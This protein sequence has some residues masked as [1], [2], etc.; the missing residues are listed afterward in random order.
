MGPGGPWELLKSFGV[1]K[2]K[3]LPGR[4]GTW[5]VGRYFSTGATWQKYLYSLVLIYAFNAKDIHIHMPG[6]QA[7]AGKSEFSRIFRP[8][9]IRR[10]CCFDVRS[11]TLIGR[12]KLTFVSRHQRQQC[13]RR[14]QHRGGAVDFSTGPSPDRG[15][16]SKASRCKVT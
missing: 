14:S 3:K 11:M 15:L 1:A 6:S 13:N 8:V 7:K 12:Y 10:R 5:D 2:L 9:T 4:I 16:V